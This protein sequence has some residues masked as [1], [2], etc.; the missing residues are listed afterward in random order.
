MSYLY[1]LLILFYQVLYVCNWKLEVLKLQDSL[2]DK[3]DYD[4]KSVKY[5]LHHP[6]L[7]FSHERV[8]QLVDVLFCF[9]EYI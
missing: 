6:N 7:E 1:P 8:K 2:N 4:T 9:H 3:N 5:E